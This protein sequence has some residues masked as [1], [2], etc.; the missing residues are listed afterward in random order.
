M[1]WPLLLLFFAV[2]IFIAAVT[3]SSFFTFLSKKYENNP[4]GPR[5][6]SPLMTY[7]DALTKTFEMR[8]T[9][10][11]W[12]ILTLRRKETLLDKE[13]IIDQAYEEVIQEEFARLKEAK[14][15]FPKTG[16]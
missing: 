14:K 9:Q 1:G 12:D 13:E 10:R 16:S 4:L 5:I 6:T 2:A 3:L 8:V 15:Y 7:R 11:A